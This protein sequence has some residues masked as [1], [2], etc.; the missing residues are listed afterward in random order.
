MSE[1]LINLHILVLD[2]AVTN[3]PDDIVT[4]PHQLVQYEC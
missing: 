2:L 4:V 1:Y 3:C